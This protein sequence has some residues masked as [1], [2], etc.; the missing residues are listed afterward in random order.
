MTS[1]KQKSR[2]KVRAENPDC[3]CGAVG[4]MTVDELKNQLKGSEINLA[5]PAC[6]QVHLTQSEIEEL[7]KEKITQSKRYKEIRSEAEA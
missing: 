5:C 2:F 6:G 4:H 7:E 3:A 1:K